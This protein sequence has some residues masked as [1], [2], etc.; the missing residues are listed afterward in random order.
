MTPGIALVGL[1]RGGLHCVRDMWLPV[2]ADELREGDRARQ[3]V[4]ASVD[5]GQS[6]RQRLL[7]LLALLGV[8]RFC[9]L[10]PGPVSPLC[11]IPDH[12]DEA[13]LF[14]SARADVPFLIAHAFFPFLPFFLGRSQFTVLQWGHKRGRSGRRA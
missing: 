14:S 1:P 2:F 10:L 11:A 13:M 5:V 8:N 3:T 4:L 7:G 12:M 9:Y 6:L